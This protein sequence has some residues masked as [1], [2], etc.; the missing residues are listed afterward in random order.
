MKTLKEYTCIPHGD[1]G[2]LNALANHQIITDRK[3]IAAINRFFEDFK[4][5][6]SYLTFYLWRSLAPQTI[7]Q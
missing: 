2:L 1:I 3:D 6:E 5:W 7:T 4:G